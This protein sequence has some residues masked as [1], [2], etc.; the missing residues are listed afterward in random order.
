MLIIGDEK[1]H[2][3]FAWM[4]LVLIL[5][6]IMGYQAQLYFGDPLTYGYSLV[7][8]EITEGKDIVGGTPVTIQERKD[9]DTGV[10]ITTGCTIVIPQQ[11][12][13]TPIYLTLLTSMFLHANLLHIAGNML[14]LFVFGRN[15]ERAMGPFLFLFF[16][17]L[18]G[19]AAGMTHV[20][21]A[22]DALTPYLGASGAV[23]GIMG[24]YFFLFPFSWVKVWLGPCAADL[25]TIVV[26]GGWVFLQYMDSLEAVQAGELTVGIA[27]W[28]HVGGF[29]AGL[30]FVFTMMT[31]M[32]ILAF[33]T[34]KPPP[35]SD[36][37]WQADKQGPRSRQRR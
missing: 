17:L 13:P 12:G 16:Y 30:G 31:T 33:L 3:G 18:V 19:V 14:F 7:P 27:Y 26:L 25:P 9:E 15:V 22:P 11:P 34:R 21:V 8:K 5:A 37:I 28:A 36:M 4:T 24:A 35:R 23:S 10:V 29:V 2:K 20:F 32:R 1:K 6:N